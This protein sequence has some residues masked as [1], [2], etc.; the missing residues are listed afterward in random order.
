MK[1]LL[2][3]LN[4]FAPLGDDADALG[5]VMSDLGMA[6]E[7]QL[8]VGEGLDGVVVAKILQID[9]IEGADKIRAVLVDAGDGEATPVVCGA[10]NIAVGDV[11]PFATV[12][13]VLP[14]DF[15]IHARKMRGVESRGMLCSAKELGFGA[16]HSGI[17]LLDAS[18]PLGVALPEALGIARDVVFDLEINPNRPD[19]MSVAGVARDVAARLGVPF[20][21]PRPAPAPTGAPTH[22]DARVEV[23]DPDLCGRFHASVLRDVT[24]GTSPQ[25]MANRLTQLGMRPINALVDISNYVM[26]E[27]GQPNHPYDLAKVPGAG[28]RVRRAHDGEVLTTLDDVDRTLSGDDL[29]ICA[30]DD[31]PVGI[32]GVMGGASCEIDATTIDVL[33]ENAWFLPMSISRTSR[34]LGLRTEASARFEKGCDPEVLE[35]AAARFAELAGQICGATVAPDPLIVSGTLP[36]RA[37][38]RVRTE[39]VNG[40]LGTDLD[41]ATIAGL[42]DPIGFATTP[43]DGHDDLDVVVPSWRYD[44]ATETDVVEE[45]ARMHG[46]ARIAPVPLSAARVGALSPW[47]AERR[48]LRHALVGFGLTEAQPMPFLAPGELARCGLDDSG[49]T[50]ANPLVAE[51]SVLRTSLLPGLVQAVAA[52][53]QRRSFGVELFEVGHVFGTPP[54]GALLP[55]E[56]E[57]LAVIRAGADASGAV[58]AWQVVVDTLAV[59]DAHLTNEAVPGLHPTRSGRVV[60]AGEAV[61]EIGE[62]DP[63]VAAAHGIAERVAWLAVDL[64]RLAQLP[65][66]DRPYRLVSRYP[67]ADVDLAFEIDEAVPVHEVE[68]TIRGALGD[69][70]AE[71]R[72]FDV[73]RGSAV[74]AGRRSLAFALKFQAPDHTLADTE[75]AA[76][77]NAAIAAVESAHAATLRG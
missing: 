6:V 60:V 10:P 54:S 67:A 3:W 14:G 12:G 21:L 19:A 11:V 50:L 13:A 71:V 59:A 70:L 37:P 63:D 9:A 72:L 46:Y 51:E 35:L 30:A 58:E 57:H 52:N 44:S 38:V 66:G 61:G 33:L 31:S 55:D 53:A 29:L 77:R 76:A 39:R 1:V 8:V 74:A 7:E 2:S 17:W 5:D 16:D 65:H 24:V 69:L 47:Q 68:A 22:E 23:L 25:W 40:L 64:T 4:E 49:I 27:L 42:L 34:R 75:V 28:L 45:V 20:T 41:R 48:R 43:V 56:R 26:L 73:F 62:I 15:A 36:S 18:T 32:A